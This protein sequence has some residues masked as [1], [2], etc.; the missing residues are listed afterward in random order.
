M[1]KL[2][3]DVDNLYPVLKFHGPS[4]KLSKLINA[5]SLSSGNTCPGAKDCLSRAD[6]DTGKIK[7]YGLFRCYMASLEAIYPSLRETVWHNTELMRSMKSRE[8]I[9]DLIERSL[10]A[11]KP[12]FIAGFRGIMRPHIGG[13]FFSKDYAMAM[14]DFCH[15]HPEMLVY[16]YTKSPHLFM[17]KDRI[18]KEDIAPNFVINVSSGGRYDYLNAY[19]TEAHI[20]YSKEEAY[21]CDLTIDHDDTLAMNPASGDFAILLHG[22]QPKGSHAQEAL[23]LLRRNG[24]TGYNQKHKSKDLDIKT[25]SLYNKI[26]STQVA[27]T[28]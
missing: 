20:V 4:G 22:N 16:C 6:R 26:M 12:E 17:K 18:L 3:I 7:D 8:E 9:V 5:Y 28:Q 1:A 21:E 13:D 25:M 15:K 14:N 11:H 2:D 27:V 24:F 19:F 10:I 23:K